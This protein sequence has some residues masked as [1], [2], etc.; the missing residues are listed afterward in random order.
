ML[1]DDLG[2]TYDG[3]AWQRWQRRFAN[4]ACAMDHDVDYD[5]QPGDDHGEKGDDDNA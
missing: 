4:I 3:S 5:A 2:G 1:Y